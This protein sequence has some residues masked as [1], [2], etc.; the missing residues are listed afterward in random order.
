MPATEK[1]LKYD[2]SDVSRTDSQKM[3][4]FLKNLSHHVMNTHGPLG[5]LTDPR[6]ITLNDDFPGDDLRGLT[7]RQSFNDQFH[8]VNKY[9][10]TVVRTRIEQY[11]TTKSDS[12]DPV[13][14]DYATLLLQFVPFGSLLLHHL[15]KKYGVEESNDAI[16]CT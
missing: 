11:L 5:S 12:D 4:T 2:F 9:F 15:D 10:Y 8:S 1:G 16:H 6:T 14:D 7:E 13:L 3:K